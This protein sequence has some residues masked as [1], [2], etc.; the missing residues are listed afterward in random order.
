LLAALGLASLNSPALGEP[1]KVG[2][3]AA[4]NPDATGQP[5]N[6]PL[7]ELLVGHDVIRNERITTKSI[8]QAQ[9]LFTDQST[10]TVA[11]NSEV[12]I[13][14]FVYDP[15]KQTGNLAAT[16]TT[17]VFRYVGGKISK[18]KDVTFYT[19]TGAVSVRGGIVLIKIEGNS[20]HA[21]FMFG[22]HMT[23]TVNGV[24]QT[25]TKFNTSISSLG[26]GPP[27]APVPFNNQTIQ[28]L[29]LEL[30]SNKSNPNTFSGVFS[31]NDQDVLGNLNG[32]HAGNNSG[33]DAVTALL[34]VLTATN[35]VPISPPPPPPPPP[36]SPLAQSPPPPSPPPAS[37][38]PPPAPPAATGHHCRRH[39]STAGLATAAATTTGATGR[40]SVTARRHLPARLRCHRPAAV[41]AKVR[42]R[43]RGH[44]PGPATATAAATATSPPP[45]SATPPPPPAHR[46]HRRR[47][48][49]PPP[50]P[51]PPA[52]PPPPPPPPASPPPPPPPPPPAAGGS[53]PPPPPAPHRHRRR[54]W[55]TAT[56][57][58]AAGL[59]A[60]AAAAAATNLTGA[61]FTNAKL[62][63]SIFTNAVITSTTDFQGANTN[64]AIGL[65]STLPTSPPPPSP[66]ISGPNYSGQ[67]LQNHDFSG[68]NR[69]GAN[70]SGANLQ[71]AIF[72][73]ADLTGA[74]F[75]NPTRGGPTNLQ[76]A[77]FKGTNLT[78]A[79][80]TGAN[81]QHANFDPPAPSGHVSASVAS[82]THSKDHG[83]D[84]HVLSGAN[85]SDPRWHRHGDETGSRSGSW[86]DAASGGAGHSWNGH[87]HA[88]AF[89]RYIVPDSVTGRAQW[90]HH[91]HAQQQSPGGAA[92]GGASGFTRYVVSG[93]TGDQPRW[94]QS[95][96][97]DT[98]GTRHR[99]WLSEGVGGSAG[100]AHP[101]W[102]AR[103]SGGAQHNR[104]ASALNRF[105]TAMHGWWRNHQLLWAGGSRAGGYRKPYGD[106]AAPPKR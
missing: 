82:G 98:S 43:R 38:P 28:S 85:G 74:N 49:P 18:Q 6:E 102:A 33:P 47:R 46:H 81:L 45:P 99:H 52:S 8:G 36:S 101:H 56:T 77:T 63:D 15:Q 19:P 14:E 68:Q 31:F 44:R 48:P 54:R 71:G 64:G 30:Q 50:P 5:P 26:G 55:P 53:P 42:R 88:G 104:D 23:M 65:P 51:P 40:A 11:R 2:V 21:Y 7:R 34:S 41:H 61:N 12:V 39:P 105:S 92:N 78:N 27:G 13:D 89:D 79:N 80:F 87:P 103:E 73:N 76:S 84:R 37:P 67:N 9:L 90:H 70:F 4:V 10:L 86:H 97:G 60:T 20:V 35:L 96:S 3:A 32:L 17:G 83:Y 16:V 93:N 95:G 25:T 69:R 91:E 94:Q 100:P 22:D 106:H 72:D 29:S 58:A 57:A 75:S 59:T 24:T 1:D 66:P 62:Q